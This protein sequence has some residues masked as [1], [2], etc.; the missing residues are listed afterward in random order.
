VIADSPTDAQILSLYE[1]YMKDLARKQST[2]R[3]GGGKRLGKGPE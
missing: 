3:T 1:S 2:V